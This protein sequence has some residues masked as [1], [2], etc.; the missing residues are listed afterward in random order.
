[1]RALPSLARG[2][3]LIAL[4][5]LTLPATAAPSKVFGWVEEGVLDPEHITVKIKL[6]TGALTSSLDAR[7]QQ[8]FTRDG[9]QWVRFNIEV[10]DSRSGKLVISQFERAVVRRVKVRGA[11]GADS[12]AVVMMD[13]CIGDRVY[14]E[15]FSLNDR[16]DMLYPVLIGRRTIRHLGLVDVSR[17]FLHEPKCRKPAR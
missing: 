11:G 16:G 5:C 7:D 15:E 14:H 1:M 10:K 2:L 6:D 9:E 8:T 3:L 4:L 13:M 17:T 12:R